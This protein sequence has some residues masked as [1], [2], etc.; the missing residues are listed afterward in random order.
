M[1]AGFL[2]QLRTWAN[3]YLLVG[4]MAATL[5]GLLFVAVSINIARVIGSATLRR[6]AVRTFNQ[7]LLLIELSVVMVMPHQ[8]K[9]TLGVAVFLLALVAAGITYFSTRG[10]V[11]GKRSR[12]SFLLSNVMFLGF[13]VSGVLIVFAGDQ[14]L[15][16]M[17]MFVIATLISSVFD[18]WGLLVELGEEL[19]PADPRGPASS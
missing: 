1:N 2:E 10:E 3:V 12:S 13:A 18:A 14:A 8:Q 7:F 11:V 16:F 19:A 17:L 15:Y 4:G 6:T 9:E 5:T